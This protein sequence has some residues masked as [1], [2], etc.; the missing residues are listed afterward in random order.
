MIF[1]VQWL[2]NYWLHLCQCCYHLFQS[3]TMSQIPSETSVVQPNGLPPEQPS[4]SQEPV[5][6]FSHEGVDP[7]V[8]VVPPPNEAST[9]QS[10]VITW[11]KW[12]QLKNLVTLRFLSS[13]ILMKTW[14]IPEVIPHNKDLLWLSQIFLEN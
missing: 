2:F 14:E 10:P 8:N 1:T 5:V 3:L 7:S 6:S 12:T 11:Y 9:N 4:Q 13:F